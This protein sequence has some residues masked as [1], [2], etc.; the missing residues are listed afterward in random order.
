[1]NNRRFKI[2]LTLSSMI[3]AGNAGA[4]ECLMDWYTKMA[5]LVGKSDSWAIADTQAS[6]TWDDWIWR[7]DVFYCNPAG[8]QCDYSWKK[9]NTQSYTWAVG[10]KIGL[11]NIPF[12]GKTIGSFELNGTYS[13][14]SSYTEEFGWSQKINQGYYAQPV[15]VVVRRWK[16]GHFQGADISTGRGCNGG[17]GTWY[18]WKGDA[19]YGQWEANIEQSRYGMY[20]IWR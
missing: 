2:A 9:S 8:G 18:Y 20:H 7:G 11:G 4:E 6:N 3:L 15:Q 17:D 16:R 12:I 19:T 5:Y 1:M 10:G 13:K 14:T